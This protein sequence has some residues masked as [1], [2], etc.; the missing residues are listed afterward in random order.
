MAESIAWQ[1]KIQRHLQWL[2][3][4]N[5]LNVEKKKRATLQYKK[6]A[7]SKPMKMAGQTKTN[8]TTS[9]I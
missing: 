2:Y 9:H 5:V 6:K 7:T 3:K 8:K 4:I 1:N